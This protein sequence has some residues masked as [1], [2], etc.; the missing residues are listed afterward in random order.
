MNDQEIE[1]AIIARVAATKLDK[2]Y[3]A[4]QSESKAKLMLLHLIRTNPAD[5]KAIEDMEVKQYL[6]KVETVAKE[7]INVFNVRSEQ[8]Q[9]RI[10]ELTYIETR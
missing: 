3:H 4:Y 2:L 10:N 6:L 8:L 9:R 5:P 7:S 1:K